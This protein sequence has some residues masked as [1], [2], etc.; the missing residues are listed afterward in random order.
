ME[1]KSMYKVINGEVYYK[2]EA[3]FMWQ[4][5]GQAEFTITDGTCIK[6]HIWNQDTNQYDIFINQ[7]IEQEPEVEP[8]LKKEDLI[9]DALADVLMRLDELEAMKGGAE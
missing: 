3:M 8:E 1:N 5:M 9:L 7:I 6:K 2:T 4:Y